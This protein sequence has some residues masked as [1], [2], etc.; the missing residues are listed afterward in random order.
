M[1]FIEEHFDAE[2]AV[3]LAVAGSFWGLL[4]HN[5]NREKEHLK[6]ILKRIEDDMQ[7]LAADIKR[8]SN[9]V[10]SID[11][12]KKLDEDID[13]LQ[14]EL[15]LAR[16]KMVSNER[17]RQLDSEFE[18]LRAIIQKTR[19]QMLQLAT[20]ES[21]DTKGITESLLRLEKAI[22]TKA[23]KGNCHLLHAAQ[24]KRSE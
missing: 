9:N 2:I 12:I 1:S 13:I 4:R 21:A 6:D 8:I 3:I 7:E 10:V 5:D 19:E 14:K 24:Q 17:V 11:A 22:D 18:G 16:E 23:D 15:N 20:K